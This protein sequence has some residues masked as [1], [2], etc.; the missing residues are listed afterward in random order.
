M[1]FQ[2]PPGTH[3]AL[4]YMVEAAV[5]LLEKQLDMSAKEFRKI[6]KICKPLC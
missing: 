4:E 1:S 5:R 6:C 2:K 3:A